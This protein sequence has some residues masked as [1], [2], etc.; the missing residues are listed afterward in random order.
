MGSMMICK[1][2]DVVCAMLHGR[3]LSVLPHHTC[4]SFNVGAIDMTPAVPVAVTMAS[5]C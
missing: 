3:Q 1:L 4:L 2:P 5:V